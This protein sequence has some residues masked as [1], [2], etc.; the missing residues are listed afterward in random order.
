[1]CADKRVGI[2][3]GTPLARGDVSIHLTM[4]TTLVFNK[5]G[6]LFREKICLACHKNDTSL[7]SAVLLKKGNL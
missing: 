7:D 1:M 2:E 6:F 3:P 5:S 4:D